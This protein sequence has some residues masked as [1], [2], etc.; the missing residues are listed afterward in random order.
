MGIFN[1]L[2]HDLFF[3]NDT[4]SH[5]SK[6]SMTELKP[7]ISKMA[8]LVLKADSGKLTAV[9]TKYQSS[10]FMRISTISELKTDI[11]RQLATE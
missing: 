7:I 4:L 5:Y 8:Q 6:Y 1:L 10:K 3:Q 9:K 2:L 11:V